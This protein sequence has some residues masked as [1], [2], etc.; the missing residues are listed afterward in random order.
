MTTGVESSEAGSPQGVLPRPSDAHA[1]ISYETNKKL[2][3]MAYLLW[4]VAGGLGGHRFYAGRT[5]SAVAI[6]LT[7][8][9]ASLMM[10]AVGIG[11]ILLLPVWIW[12]F[13]DAFRIPGWIREHNAL[14]AH[15]L[16]G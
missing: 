8:I 16:L 2:L 9:F 13:V 4:F 7:T 15:Q 1:I 6:L 12:I 5:K 10:L 3:G 11:Y 14:L